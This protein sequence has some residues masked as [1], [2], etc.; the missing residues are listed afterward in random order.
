M[1]RRDSVR[2]HV[3]LLLLCMVFLVAAI[4]VAGTLGATRLARDVGVLTEDL[5]SA[6]YSNLALRQR[7]SEAQADARGWALSDGSGYADAYRLA[8]SAAEVEIDRLERLVAD[9]PAMRPKVRAEVR[10]ARGWM[11]FSRRVVTGEAGPYRPAY[12]TR[13][14]RLFDAFL[15]RHQEVSEGLDGEV[16]ALVAE[17]RDRVRATVGF[18]VLTSVLGLLAT[19]LLGLRLVRRVSEPLHAMQASVERLSAGDLAARVPTTGPRE[20]RRVAAALN[21]LAVENQESRGREAQVVDRLRALDRAKD[22]FVSTVSHELRTPLT[23]IA[24]YVEL[25]ADGFEEGCSA[26][27]QGMLTVVRRNVDRLRTL[28]EDL[29]TLSSVE[30]EAFRTSF[31]VLDLS[32]LATDVAHDVADMAAR[33]GVRVHTSGPGYPVLVNGDAGQLSRALLNLVS[34]A[35]KFSV[36]G[37]EVLIRLADT[38][39]NAVVSVVD[40]GLGIPSPELATVGTR[41]FRAS[42]ALEAEIPGTGLGLRIVQTIADNHGGRLVVESVEGQGTTARLV[43]PRALVGAAR[44]PAGGIKRPETAITPG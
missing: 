24:G 4:A 20:V 41:F 7:L 30:A 2:G 10:A 21:A 6:A 32:H 22:D 37:G 19:A 44:V 40:N 31:D 8:L 34:N 39:G 18:V 43:V 23:S 29:L 14:Q 5:R 26:Q 33:A 1:T 15:D 38:D 42:N 13:G 36:D 28:I 12:L 3:V 16:D 25:F 35:V 11:G 9:D 17:A 27:Q